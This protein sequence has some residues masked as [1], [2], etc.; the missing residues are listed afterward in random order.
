MSLMTNKILPIGS[1]EAQTQVNEI[2]H[3]I[4]IRQDNHTSVSNDIH[5]AEK[6]FT[7]ANNDQSTTKTHSESS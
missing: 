1:F 5:N 4:T 7:V 6:V 3:L 2:S